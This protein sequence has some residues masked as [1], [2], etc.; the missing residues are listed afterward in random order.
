[1][2]HVVYNDC[3]GEFSLSREALNWLAE[4]GVS[5]AYDIMIETADHP[6]I[7]VDETMI[8]LERHDSLLVLCV[9]ELG[10][11]KSSG[12]HAFLRVRSIGSRKYMI[13]NVGGIET[14]LTPQEVNWIQIE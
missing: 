2:Y 7:S 5:K 9:S 14:V 3:Q 1:M 4:R 13:R 12:Q 11:E 6:G 8:G 10:T